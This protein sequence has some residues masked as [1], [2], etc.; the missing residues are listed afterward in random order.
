MSDATS[1][2]APNKPWLSQGDIFSS[3]PIVR[4]GVEGG[5][6]VQGLQRGPAL[7]ISNDCAIDK[8]SGPGRSTLEYLSFLPIQDVAAL[9]RGR[10]AALRGQGADLQPYNA[11]YLGELS[12]IG[13]GYADLAQPFTLPALLLRTEL[14]DFTDAETG[15]GGD[16]RIVATMHDTRVGTLSAASRIV[17]WRKWAIQ[18]TRFDLDLTDVE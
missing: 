11:L 13:V 14:R 17:L 12:E 2:V 9:N 16:R 18:W 10:A 15:E 8:K 1:L 6:A 3:V 4:A 5:I 7:L